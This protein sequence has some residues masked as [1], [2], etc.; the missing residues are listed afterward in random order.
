MLGEVGG[1][2][3]ILMRG[4]LHVLDIDNETFLFKIPEGTVFG[5][6]TVLQHVEVRGGGRAVP[7]SQPAMPKP[8][9]HRLHA[10]RA[11]RCNNLP[12]PIP[13]RLQ[14]FPRWKRS[15]NVWCAT[16]CT[17]LR[18]AQ[19]G[20]HARYDKR[21]HAFNLPLL[22]RAL[23]Y[24]RTSQLQACAQTLN[25]AKSN[26]TLSCQHCCG[27]SGGHDG[28]AHALPRADGDLE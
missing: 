9:H 16:P 11:W 5:E 27:F 18:I 13:T 3:F 20:A 23:L 24:G 15:E 25:I 12:N 4:E 6:A 2:V 22:A 21:I 10:Q 28:P 17:M 1:D 19:V 26:K 7:K 8:T 14:G